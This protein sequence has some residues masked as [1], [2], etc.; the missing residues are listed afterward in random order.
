[1]SREQ[2]ADRN[3]RQLKK[4]KAGR[5]SARL[6]SFMRLSHSRA[7]STNAAERFDGVDDSVAEARFDVS[8]RE[9]DRNS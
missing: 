7:T 5:L 3:F 8:E 2:L 4:M 6:F 1:M 9:Y